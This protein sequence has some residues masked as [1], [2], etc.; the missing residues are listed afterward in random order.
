MTTELVTKRR[1]EEEDV[2]HIRALEDTCNHAE[3]IRIKFNWSMM[4]TRDAGYQS[5]FCCYQ[6]GQL[7]GYAPLDRFGSG[8]EVTAAVLPAFRRQGIFRLLFEAARQEAKR[9]QASE[10][11]LVSYP[12]SPAGTAALAHLD[13]T[14]KN[15]EYH[16][17]AQS[18]T[19]PT[20]PVSQ[21][22]RKSVV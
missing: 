5:D 7:I 16:M 11:L 10:L 17:E 22:D 4:N 3:G 20:L 6:E 13:V 18:A 21:I 1:L 2:A 19:L 12:A 9:C 15:S 14:Y 8:F